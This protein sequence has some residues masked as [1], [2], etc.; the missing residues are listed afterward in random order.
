MPRHAH[1]KL[2]VLRR[3]L[4]FQRF[5]WDHFK[6]LPR[7]KVA[8][9]LNL[10]KGVC[11]EHRCVRTDYSFLKKKSQIRH[12]GDDVVTKSAGRAWMMHGSFSIDSSYIR[13]VM[14]NVE[15]VPNLAHVKVLGDHPVLS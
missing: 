11:E 5:F 13:H 3:P 15:Q 12:R 8:K 6:L 7:C 14:S 9:Q 2:H 4:V 10:K 1:P